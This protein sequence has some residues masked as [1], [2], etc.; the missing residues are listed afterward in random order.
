M[1]MCELEQMEEG[2]H[3]YRVKFEKVEYPTG[4]LVSDTI[5]A[6]D[7]PPCETEREAWYLAGRLSAIGDGKFVNI[8]V[9]DETGK[10]VRPDFVLR[11][12][13]KLYGEVEDET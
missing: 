3:T 11:R 2:N 4:G 13:G 8:Y 5:P 9:V 7:E 6:Y 12:K 10:T 1:K